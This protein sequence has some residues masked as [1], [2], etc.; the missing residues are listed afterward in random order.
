MH[1]ESRGVTA[2]SSNALFSPANVYLASKADVLETDGDQKRT[3]ARID[4]RQSKN[5]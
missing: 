1:A 4:E 5:H 2:K 3:F